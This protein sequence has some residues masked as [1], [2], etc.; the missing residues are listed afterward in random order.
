MFGFGFWAK[1]ANQP[2]AALALFEQAPDC[3][4]N[5][6]RP[7]G[8]VGPFRVADSSGRTHKVYIEEAN[9]KAIQSRI[10]QQLKRGGVEPYTS[11]DMVVGEAE[12]VLAALP[13]RLLKT[14]TVR[15]DRD[16]WEAVMMAFALVRE[17]MPNHQNYDH[18]REAIERELSQAEQKWD[19]RDLSDYSISLRQSEWI[20]L[21]SAMLQMAQQA[22]DGGERF[23][24]AVQTVEQQVRSYNASSR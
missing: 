16:D 4:V 13:E 22:N 11:T 18:F 7:R 15:F 21:R 17:Q 5:G 24:G 19:R 9:I 8:F 1:V 6:D 12:K 14:V 2:E 10:K 3:L 20:E 23:A